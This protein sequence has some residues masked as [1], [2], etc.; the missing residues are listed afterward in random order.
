MA[1]PSRPD[2]A[3]SAAFVPPLAGARASAF[4]ARG[5][6]VASPVGTA[7]AASLTSAASR[8]RASGTARGSRTGASAVAG[9]PR[10]SMPTTLAAAASAAAST[11]PPSS[12]SSSSSSSS[13]AA[14]AAAA[15]AVICCWYRPVPPDAAAVRAA[16]AAAGDGATVAREDCFNVLLSGGEG[17]LTDAGRGVLEGLLAE[18]YEPTALRTAPHLVAP[19]GAGGAVLEVGPR[20]NFQTAWSSN[21]VSICAAR[22]VGGITRLER[23]RRY[24]LLG[25]GGAPVAADSPT[26][27]AFAA[28][29]HDRMTETVYGA[30]LTS[31]D[32]G[33]TPA[34]TY[35]VPLLAE[36]RAGLEASMLRWASALMTGTCSTFT[37]CLWASSAA[38]QRPLSSQDQRQRPK[39]FFFFFFHALLCPFV[40]CFNSFSRST[41]Y[42]PP[43]PPPTAFPSYS[44]SLSSSGAPASCPS[45]K[46]MRSR[47]PPRPPPPAPTSAASGPTPPRTLP[48]MAS[49][50]DVAPPPPPPQRP[51]ALVWRRRRRRRRRQRRRGVPAPPPP[52]RWAR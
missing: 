27:A 6:G 23:S 22:G 3:A 16:V 35:T 49:P 18:T 36:G 46:P 39:S 42:I 40:L 31:M 8:R 37:T 50:S 29:V 33:L 26:A 38:T 19:G 13:A 28:A 52:G 12:S 1:P 21:A 45:R 24:L 10:C 43:P 47:R 44:S 11:P 30:P 2:G 5:G 20:L 51:P 7:P 15:E 9:A 48:N 14:A 17:A 4:S 25:P 34:A 32:S 41:T